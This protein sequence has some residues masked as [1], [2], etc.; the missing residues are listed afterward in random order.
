MPA[1]TP[2]GVVDVAGGW[3]PSLTL[4]LAFMS[5]L[6]SKCRRKAEADGLASLMSNT[7]WRELCI[8]FSLLDVKPRWRTLDLLNGHL[9]A[10]DREWFHHVGPDYC[11]IEWLEIDPSGC[12]GESVR[13]L[14]CEVGVPFEES[15]H[16]LRVIGYKR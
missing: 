13:A 14:L 9:S 12:D 15:T 16:F 5:T 1:G 7:K 2:N 11:S 6:A 3:L 8:A 10:W 4:A